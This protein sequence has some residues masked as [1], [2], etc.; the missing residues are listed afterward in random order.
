MGDF[1]GLKELAEARESAGWLSMDSVSIK[2]ILA[3]IAENKSLHGSCRALGDRAVKRDKRRL[4][5]LEKDYKKAVE[6]ILRW[7][8]A[9]ILAQDEAANLK[10]ENEALRKDADRYRR[11]RDATLESLK[12]TQDEFDKKFDS[13]MMEVTG[14]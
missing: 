2:Q 10:A 7:S 1:S 9:A 11:M 6:E 12:D 8:D 3:L 14:Q 13:A 5:K 4:E